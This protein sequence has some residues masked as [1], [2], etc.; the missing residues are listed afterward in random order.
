MR[1]ASIDDPNPNR[2]RRSRTAEYFVRK[3]CEMW[4]DCFVVGLVV[5]CLLVLVFFLS[6][7][8]FSVSNAHA[9]VTSCIYILGMC[10]LQT[11]LNNEMEWKEQKQDKRVFL[12]RCAVVEAVRFQFSIKK[13]RA[14]LWHTLFTEHTSYAERIHSMQ[15]SVLPSE[16]LILLWSARRDC[17]F[18]FSSLVRH[19]LSANRWFPFGII[20]PIFVS[21]NTSHHSYCVAACVVCGMSNTDIVHINSIHHCR[22]TD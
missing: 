4:V 20:S 9:R 3:N 7:P 5:F 14:C 11:K 2:P 13:N 16:S 15:H 1:A 19:C 22:T 21:M 18:R 10:L 6:S 8:L 12:N 17:V